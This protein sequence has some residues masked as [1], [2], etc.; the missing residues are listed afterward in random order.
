MGKIRL[1]KKKKAPRHRGSVSAEATNTDFLGQCRSPKS[2]L[3]PSVFG[4]FVSFLFCGVP[5]SMSGEPVTCNWRFSI[6]RWR[7]PTF[8][9]LTWY[10]NC[11]YTWMRVV[12]ITKSWTQWVQIFS[13][14]HSS[15]QLRLAQFP[16]WKQTGCGHSPVIKAMKAQLW[17]TKPLISAAKTYLY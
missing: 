5:L 14:K 3:K 1:R 17:N 13:T 12:Y 9:S 8:W 4:I 2:Y 6:E 7:V 11:R 15:M 16:N 10:F